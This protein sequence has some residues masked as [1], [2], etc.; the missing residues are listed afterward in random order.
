MAHRVSRSAHHGRHMQ[1]PAVVG[2]VVYV[3]PRGYKIADGSIVTD[4]KQNIR[5]LGRSGEVPG[6]YSELV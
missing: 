1:H 3:R 2:D 6:Y 5:V 4:S